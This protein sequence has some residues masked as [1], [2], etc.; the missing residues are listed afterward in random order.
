M[1]PAHPRR[2]PQ[3]VVC[4]NMHLSTA[5]VHQ[6]FDYRSNHSYDDYCFYN[7][8]KSSNNS[9]QNRESYNRGNH[10]YANYNDYLCSS[11]SW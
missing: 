1:L 9:A 3:T 10:S 7:K 5:P 11:N 6:E 2:K 8:P 4:R